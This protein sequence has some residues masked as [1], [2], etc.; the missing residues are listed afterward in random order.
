MWLIE[1]LNNFIAKPPETF[2]NE[3]KLIDLLENSF[4]TFSNQ[5]LIKISAICTQ[6]NEKTLPSKQ[7]KTSS[8]LQPTI[9]RKNSKKR[10]LFQRHMF[11][12]FSNQ[13]YEWHDNTTKRETTL[14]SKSSS[15]PGSILWCLSFDSNP[16]QYS[17]LLQWIEL[18]YSDLKCIA[19][20]PTRMDIKKDGKKS[21]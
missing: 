11:S 2:I 15:L 5:T 20:K 3:I 21:K 6:N 9:N 1:F 16:N 19:M 14:C 4:I 7:G 18:N 10:K 8:S 12:F 17:L 13:K